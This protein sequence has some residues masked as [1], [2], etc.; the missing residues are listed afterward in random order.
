MRRSSVVSI[1]VTADDVVE[2]DE[3]FNV[4]LNIPSSVTRGIKAG[5]RNNVTVTIIDFTGEC[6]M[7]CM[8]GAAYHFH[9][10]CKNY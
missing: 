6:T 8:F 7:V 10:S 5:H 2:G 1:P 4:I 3:T 9:N